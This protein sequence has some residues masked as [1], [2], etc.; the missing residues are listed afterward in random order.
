MRKN[1]KKFLS[2]LLAVAVM[3]GC[4]VAAPTEAQAAPKTTTLKYDTKKGVV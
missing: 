3:A 1:V 4:T 2:L